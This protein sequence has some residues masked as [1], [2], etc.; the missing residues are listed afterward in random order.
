MCVCMRLCLR[1]HVCVCVCVCVRAAL[2]EQYAKGLLK[3]S[4]STLADQEEGWEREPVQ[5]ECLDNSCHGD[6]S[7]GTVTLCWFLYTFLIDF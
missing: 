4:K 7:V 2:E 1:V 6:G 5:A 3:L